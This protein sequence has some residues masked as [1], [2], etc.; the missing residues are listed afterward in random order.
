[1]EIVT[2]DFDKYLKNSEE[3]ELDKFLEKKR[4]IDIK[5]IESKIIEVNINDETY[6]YYLQCI[7]KDNKIIKEIEKIKNEMIKEYCEENKINYYKD[8]KNIEKIQNRYILRIFIDEFF[9]KKFEKEIN[10]NKK[11]DIRVYFDSINSIYKNEDKRLVF[12]LR[13]KDL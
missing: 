5:D 9:E 12:T 11:R 10:I 8:I 1:M 7:I 13:Y 6:V 4:K 2:F 3:N